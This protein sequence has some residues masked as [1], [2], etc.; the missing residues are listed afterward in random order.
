[1]TIYI[2]TD[3]PNTLSLAIREAVNNNVLRTW[4]IV[5]DGNGE[6]FLTHSPD[7]WFKR[8]L[9]DFTETPGN[10][11]V[12]IKW[13]VNREPGDDVKG[14]Y[15][16]RFTEVLMVHFNDFFNHLEIYP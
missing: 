16:G 9:L 11:V 1:M 8:A 4:V 2:K 15:I 14:Y 5:Q 3:S 12:S 7:Q 13:Y 10:L 6:E